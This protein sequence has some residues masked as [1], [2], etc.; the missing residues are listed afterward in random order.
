MMKRAGQRFVTLG[1]VLSLLAACERGG[2]EEDAVGAQLGEMLYRDG[3][4]AVPE[5]NVR[6][7]EA[8]LAID[9]DGLPADSVLGAFRDWLVV[10][11]VEH[12]DRMVSA[13]NSLP[14]GAP[15]VHPNARGLS[16]H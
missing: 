11:A 5:V 1:I 15:G 2:R 16:S 13:R 3:L 9:R 10:W 14:P 12:P 4:M 6:M 7:R 8:V